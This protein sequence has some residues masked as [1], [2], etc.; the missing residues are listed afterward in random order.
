MRRIPPGTSSVRR[1]DCGVHYI[2]D[3][4]I[5]VH[6][7]CIYLER[8]SSIYSV[9]IRHTCMIVHRDVDGRSSEISLSTTHVQKIDF[10]C[11]NKCPSACATPAGDDEDAVCV[12]VHHARCFDSTVYTVWE[13]CMYYTTRHPSPLT[14][15]P[16]P[17]T[18]KPLWM[19]RVASRRH[20]TTDRRDRWDG[21]VRPRRRRRGRARAF[22]DG[23][24]RRGG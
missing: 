2:V 16:S 17:L 4:V 18:P 21:V 22:V 19:G 24:R 8:L 11:P 12:C 14:P 1:L 23:E 7:V 5:I 20:S 13:I 9:C 3:S 15:H 10:Y 6:C